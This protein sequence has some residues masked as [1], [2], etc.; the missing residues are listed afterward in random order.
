MYSVDHQ[1]SDVSLSR[2]DIDAQERHRI[3]Q[4]KE[5]KEHIALL[6][7]QLCS[8]FGKVCPHC[9]GSMHGHGTTNEKE[10]WT[11]AGLIRVKVKR[12][13]CADCGYLVL[14]A[15][16]LIEEE[17]LSSLA[18]KFIALCRR[19]SFEQSRIQLKE[20]FG[21]DIPVMTL[22]AY[23]KRQSAYF[24]DELIQETRKLYEL[25]SAPKV[26]ATLAPGTPLYLAID[27]GLVRDW[28]HTHGLQKSNTKFNTAYCA[29]FF[30]G[31]KL[32][33]K[34]PEAKKRYT[35]TGRY[36]HVTTVTDVNTYFRELVTLSIKRG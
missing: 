3:L 6:D 2:F 7:K 27:E 21:I 11:L 24:D 8:D 33:T 18:Q 35:L 10:L 1:L 17:L 22:H 12:L 30:D 26:E 5:I 34:N 25:G 28:K 4:R 19:N 29:V 15:R 16:K 13:R 36:G 20:D 31:R 9:K 32:I 14:P 23:V